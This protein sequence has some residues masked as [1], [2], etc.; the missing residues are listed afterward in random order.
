MLKTLLGLYLIV[1]AV[2]FILTFSFMFLASADKIKA[3]TVSFK[4]VF[5]GAFYTAFRLSL[6]WPYYLVILVMALIKS[7]EQ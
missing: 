2:F 5:W 1:A 4:Q 6:L 7:K 3:G